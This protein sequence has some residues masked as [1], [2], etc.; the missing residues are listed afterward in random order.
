MRT[1][2]SLIHCVTS[3][4]MYLPLWR[5]ALGSNIFHLLDT[6]T[7]RNKKRQCLLIKHSNCSC[8]Y[9]SNFRFAAAHLATTPTDM[10]VITA[11]SSEP[12]L[13]SNSRCHQK[14]GCS[15]LYCGV[16]LLMWITRRRPNVTSVP[17]L[18]GD[19]DQQSPP[20]ELRGCVREDSANTESRYE[21]LRDKPWPKMFFL[22]H[23]KI[24]VATQ[25]TNLN[26][27]LWKEVVAQDAVWQH[28]S[29]LWFPAFLLHP[30]SV[31]ALWLSDH[32][33]QRSKSSYNKKL[34]ELGLCLGSL[35]RITDGSVELSL[36][37]VNLLYPSI[38]RLNV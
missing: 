8:L 2:Y 37:L 31:F 38:Y 24:K 26:C 15:Q 25:L 11:C 14:Q 29:C 21:K 36:E 17:L 10:P 35:H 4:V 20:G 19:P 27:G 30:R 7:F 3:I 18:L 23:D 28:E 6:T 1:L 12:V 5:N 32:C 33:T 22:S 16:C 9:P 34:L 13:D